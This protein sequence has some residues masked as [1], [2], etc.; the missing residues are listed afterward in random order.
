MAS[1]ASRK[2]RM[3]IDPD[4]AKRP[5]IHELRRTAVVTR[6]TDGYDTD[7]ISNDFGRRVRWWIT[8]V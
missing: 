3:E 2:T 6:W 4:N 5:T 8:A 7:Q 1:G